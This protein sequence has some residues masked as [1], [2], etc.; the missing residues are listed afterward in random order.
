MKTKFWNFTKKEESPASAELYL[1]GDISSESWY[2][3]E[4]T[5]KQFADDLDA[6]GKV[7]DLDVYIFSG[8][9][10]IFAGFAIYS[11]LD[12]ANCRII[13]HIDGLAASAATVVAMAADKVVIPENATFMIHN[14][15]TIAM[16]NKYDLAEQIKQ[17][18]MIDEQIANIYTARTGKDLDEV[19]A[20]MDA[21]TWMTGAEAVENGFADELIE[22]KKIAASVDLAIMAHY[23]NAP[24]LDFSAESQEETSEPV[25]DIVP[26]VTIEGE[27]SE[28]QI[29]DALAEQRKQFAEKK[30]HY[31]EVMK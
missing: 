2:G 5:P 18:D 14:A 6:L 12:R 30:L 22:N 31:Y 11:I 8:G 16:G 29:S 23:K 7:D 26:E 13:A 10:D 28:P 15:W 20:L 25:S 27:A 24:V 17:L 9:G 19:K 21:E 4:V 1:Y 3:D